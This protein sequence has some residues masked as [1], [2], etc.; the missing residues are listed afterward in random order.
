MKTKI[1]D[2]EKGKINDTDKKRDKYWSM[3]KYR[4]ERMRSI[5]QVGRMAFIWIQMID[6]SYVMT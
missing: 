5:G 2:W 6:S 4:L 3:T 1:S